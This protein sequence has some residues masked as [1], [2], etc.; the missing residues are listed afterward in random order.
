MGLNSVEATNVLRMCAVR[1]IRCALLGWWP[2]LTGLCCLVLLVLA[3]LLALEVLAVEV[4]CFADF[5]FA[6]LEV[7]ALLADASLLLLDVERVAA[8]F[9]PL[10]D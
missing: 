1:A 3:V 4:P 6:V 5:A 8:G 10:E 7:R 9:W 2:L